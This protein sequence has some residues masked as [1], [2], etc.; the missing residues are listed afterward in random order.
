MVNE[1]PIDT[2]NEASPT[3]FVD[4]GSSTE[5]DLKKDIAELKSLVVV[6]Y[7]LLLVMVGGIILDTYR[8]KTSTY[9]EWRDEVREQ[10]SKMDTLINSSN[11]DPTEIP[12][13]P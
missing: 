6:G 11:Y 4:P 3:N 2:S 1:T 12:L 7:I 13:R 5:G 8:F 10:N 9:Q